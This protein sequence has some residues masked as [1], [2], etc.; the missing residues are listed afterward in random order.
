MVIGQ[1]DG[2]MHVHVAINQAVH[3]ITISMHIELQR[4]KYEHLVCIYYMVVSEV[5][6]LMC[7]LYIILYC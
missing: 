6:I 4:L 5:C 3:V 2:Y 1:F 7:C